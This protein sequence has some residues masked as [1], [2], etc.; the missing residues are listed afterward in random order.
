MNPEEHKDFGD[1]A[2]PEDRGASVRFAWDNKYL[3]FV[4]K[5]TDKDVIAKRVGKNIWRDDLLEIY[6]DPE[7]DGL[8]WNAPLTPGRRYLRF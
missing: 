1:F 3:Y 8:F 4:A 2:G 6:I 7:G 5:V